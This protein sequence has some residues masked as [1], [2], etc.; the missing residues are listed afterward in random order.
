[1]LILSN[2]EPVAS[3]GQRTVFFHP[4]IDNYLV[5]VISREYMESV[6]KMWPISTRLRRLPYYWVY[7]NEIVEFFFVRE[8]EVANK[9][10][11]QTIIGFAD[12]D[13]GLGLVV[14]AVRKKNGELANSLSEII[15]NGEYTQQHLQG[16][17]ELIDWIN[18]NYV[19]VRD[20]T[21]RNIVW[22]EQNEHFV[23]IDGIGV[24]NLPSLRSFSKSY[25]A[26]ANRK[27]TEKLRLRLTRQLTS[28][29]YI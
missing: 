15:I 29:G 26:R 14:E 3:G 5:K 19:V 28:N 24:K 12:T 11:I 7:I 25:N 1:M 10:F 4:E 6:K 8:K 9:H 23:L 22:D 13:I 2:K 16:M 17:E 20:L 27:R 18:S 21:T